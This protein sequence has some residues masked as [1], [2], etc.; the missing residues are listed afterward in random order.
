MKN[1]LHIILLSS[2]FD[3]MAM[4]LNKLSFPSFYIEDPLSIQRELRE[5]NTKHFPDVPV[6]KTL[7]KVGPK[8]FLDGETNKLTNNYYIPLLIVRTNKDIIDKVN[9]NIYRWNSPYNMK[10]SQDFIVRNY[11]DNIWSH[12]IKEIRNIYFVKS[13]L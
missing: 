8:I 11:Y 4:E 13:F 6:K 9:G 10:L 12:H 5:F 3:Y 7:N 1:K 2:K